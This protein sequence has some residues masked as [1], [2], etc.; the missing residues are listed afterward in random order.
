MKGRQKREQISDGVASGIVALIFLILGFQLAV[1]VMK[2]VRKPAAVE[3]TVSAA[4]PPE[5]VADTCHRDGQ[6]VP[7][8]NGSGSAKVPYRTK[9]GAKS[10]LGGYGAPERK[11]GRPQRKYESFPF[12]PNTV[13]VEE[14]ERL[15]LTQKQAQTVENYRNKGGR[16]RKTSDFAQMYV[17]SD[18]LFAR[19]EPFI[20]IPKLE[21]NSADSAALLNLRGIGPYYAHKILEYRRRLGGFSDPGQLLEID[22]F[23][24]ERFDGLKAEIEADSLK[25]EKIA[26]WGDDSIRMTSHPYMGQ[27]MYRSVARFKKVYDT[28]SWSMENLIGEKVLTP[29]QLHKIFVYLK[30]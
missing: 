1:F 19:L 4:I 30:F 17:V 14:L 28:A 9:T 13:T 12:D 23:G 21:L 18:T 3:E 6:K 10:R 24:Q 25:I 22:G 7:V 8:R 15:G 20:T 29:E 5:P 16:F 2:V 27:K 26:L 11:S